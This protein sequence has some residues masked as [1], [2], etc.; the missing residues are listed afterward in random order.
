MQYLINLTDASAHRMV[1]LTLPEAA[2]KQAAIDVVFDIIGSNTDDELSLSDI[3]SEGQI[4]D[5][6]SIQQVI[7]DRDSEGLFI[8]DGI[9]FVA[10]GKP[11]NPDSPMISSFVQ[12]ENNGS[13]YMRCDLRVEGGAQAI[14][15][16]PK[17]TAKASDPAGA[18]IK[19]VEATNGQAPTDDIQAQVEEYSRIYFLH[20]V[21]VG[22]MIDVTREYPELTNVLAYAEKKGLVE[23]DVK[24]V[25]YKLSAEGLR[26]HDSYIAE[27]QDLI[28]RY[29]IYSDVEID[30]TGRVRFDTGLGKDL[31]VPAFEMDGINPFRARFLLGLNDG[32]WDNL[33]NWM[34]V[35]ESPSWY[36]EIFE[37]IEHAASID[38]LGRDR[39]A[40]IMDQAR[41]TLRQG[42]S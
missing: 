42:Q 22:P 16:A 28:R 23:V 8:R 20:K 11:L 31:R 25:A 33:S 32:E 17:S 2:V 1:V 4:D 9:S 19:L 14:Q 15:V 7:F 34:D 10:N 18:N 6:K 12:A 27:A 30:S 29:D 3:V 21:R 35:F 38:D 13:K 41:A 24:L 40:Q 39:M 26:L 36:G 5:L 37:P